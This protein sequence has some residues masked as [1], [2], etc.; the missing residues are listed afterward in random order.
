MGDFQELLKVDKKE[1]FDFFYLGLRDR[2]PA[3]RVID[4]ETKYTASILASFAQTSS[5]DMVD[6]PPFSS[7][8][9]IFD[10]FVLPGSAL[11]NPNL[12]ALAGAQSLFLLG[13]FP[14]QMARRHNLEWYIE[15]GKSFY[16]KAGLYST[17][18]G[19]RYLYGRLSNNFSV[20]TRAYQRLN[21]ELYEERFLL[22]PPS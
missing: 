9:E 15:L 5:C 3:E 7:L 10:N 18:S 6:M 1:T 8:S 12:L 13:V 14:S 4:A 11:R 17:N 22:P 21:R 16:R 2:V 20:W 19:E